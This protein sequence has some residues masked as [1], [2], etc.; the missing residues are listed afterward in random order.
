MLKLWLQTQFDHSVT[1]AR[2]RGSFLADFPFF[3]A[4]VAAFALLI[5]AYQ[6]RGEFSEGDTYGVLDGLLNGQATGRWLDDPA[7][8][9]IRFSYGYVALIY[10]LAD[11]HLIALTREGLI[12]A[13]N[14]IGFTAAV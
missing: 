8:Y 13:I 7:Q 9:G 11:L 4:V 10:W 2:N 14:N 3:V 5:G 1:S 6:Y 12:E